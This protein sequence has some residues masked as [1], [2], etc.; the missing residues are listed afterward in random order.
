[1]KVVV[2]P[3]IGWDKTPEFA[4]CTNPILIGAIVRDCLQAGAS[5]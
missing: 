4:A 5:K 2:K 1:M 3:N